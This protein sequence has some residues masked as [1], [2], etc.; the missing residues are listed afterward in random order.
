MA[1][2]I[3]CAVKRITKRQRHLTFL[4]N[5]SCLSILLNRCYFYFD[6]LSSKITDSQQ[7][8][9][10]ILNQANHRFTT[11]MQRRIY[12]HAT[13]VAIRPLNEE[14]A[15]QAAADLLG[16]L[17]VFTVMQI[18]TFVICSKMSS[19]IQRQI[20]CLCILRK[21]LQAMWFH[22]VYIMFNYDII[23]LNVHLEF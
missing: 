17:F 6:Q 1:F 13:D 2:N 18:P 22:V 12:G 7:I 10:R 4:N 19:E 8:A 15:V 11:Q 14:K 23:F 9:C 16:E 5:I 3:I 20:Y 21:K